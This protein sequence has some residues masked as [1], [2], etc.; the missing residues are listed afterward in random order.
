MG[1]VTQGNPKSSGGGVLIQDID[2]SDSR[3]HAFIAEQEAQ[4]VKP[5]DEF[6]TELLDIVKNGIDNSGIRLPWSKTHE[7]IV[8]RPGEVSVM[9]GYSGHYKS[10][11]ASQMALFAA[12]QSKVGIM[13]F[14]MPIPVSLLRL[15]RMAAGTDS[16]ATRFANDFATWMHDRLYFYDRLDAVP[17]ERVLGCALHMA[18]LGIKLIVIDC[19]IM[20]RGIT[21]DPEK[22]AKFL[23]TLS[24]LS[25]ATGAHIM[26]IHHAR[27]PGQGTET[28]NE[29]TKFDLRGASDLGD[30]ASTIM[31]SHNMKDKS[32]L[33]HQVELGQ[34]LPPEKQDYLDNHADHKLIVAKQRNGTFEGT[35]HLFHHQPSMQFTGDSRRQPM[36][37]D[38]PRMGI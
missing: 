31:I 7:K 3:I 36:T 18:N 35:F 5:G 30:M 25:K 22:E 19:L 34:S 11:L 32:D 15:C 29:P 21:R 1:A 16:P 28:D 9:F 24:A 4:D 38:I 37:F 20:V 6:R 17:P 12:L 2:F 26:L 33:R 8:L 13:S 27:K 23:S 10:T 14:E